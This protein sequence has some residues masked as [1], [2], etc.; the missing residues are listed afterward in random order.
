MKMIVTCRRHPNLSRPAFFHHLRN[1]HWPLVREHREVL[2]T[3]QGYV[4]N[5]A[6]GDSE[7]SPDATPLRVATER[8]SVIE[9]F[10]ARPEDL[11][12]LV[13]T[14]AYLAYVRPDEA[15]FNDLSA[16]LM[17]KTRP[18]CCFEA[19]H[20]GRC[21][22]F[23]FL[24]RTRDF[25]ALHFADQLAAQARRLALDPFYTSNVDRHVHNHPISP[26]DGH[27]FG[28]GQFDCVRELWAGSFAALNA[29]A[30]LLA[31]NGADLE[32]SFSIF[33]TEFVMVEPQ[34]SLS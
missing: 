7:R 11:L 26:Q 12:R 18:E 19:A 21:K 6:V 29:V 34:Q 14:P 17:V 9:L 25:T 27:G 5:H 32:R 1:V 28:Q 22:R 13:E 33:A 3:L 30:P 15:R 8:D 31:T 23:D 2:A 4:Q 16:N 24:V 10:F 20:A